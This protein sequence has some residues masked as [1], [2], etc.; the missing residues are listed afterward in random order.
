LH[1]AAVYPKPL[2]ADALWES[3]VGVLGNLGGPRDGAAPQSLGP[4]AGRSGFEGLFKD[5]F[6]FDPSVKAQDVE[7]SIAQALLL[8]NSPPINARITAQG[9]NLLA[10]ILAAYPDDDE[11]LRM[12]YQRVLARKP[13][14]RELEKCR[15][16]LA[17]ASRRAEAFEDVLWVLL[18]STEFRTKR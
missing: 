13:T 18:N 4:Y 10:R 7:G 14:D 6:G 9:P 12:V 16:Y 5:E 11:A 17:K 3:L 1:F 8:M 15:A 2:G